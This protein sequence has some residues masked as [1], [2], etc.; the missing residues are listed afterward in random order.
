MHYCMK[1]TRK[2]R[3]PKKIEIISLLTF[4][5]RQWRFS[6]CLVILPLK[7][8]KN[9]YSKKVSSLLNSIEKCEC[10]RYFF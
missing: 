8:K 7:H 3:H 10:E 6:S 5:Y 2:R 4:S 9:D 1:K